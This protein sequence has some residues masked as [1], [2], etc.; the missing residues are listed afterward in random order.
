MAVNFKSVR[1]LFGEPGPRR[2]VQIV[3]ASLA[4]FDLIFYLFAIGPLGESDRER[5]LQGQSLERQLRDRQQQVARLQAIVRKV[6]TARVEG[7]KLLGEITLPRRTAFSTIVSEL[8]DAGKQ[9]GVELRDRG[10]NVDAIEGSETL[11]MLTITQGLEGNYEN[12]VRFLN[13]LDRSRRF[14]IIESLGAAPQQSGAQQSGA[15][16]SVTLKL[17]AFVKES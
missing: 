6:E 4:L 9:A 13:L 1:N 16:L 5:R 10:L 14:L 3:L 2:N 17:D 11:S 15:K 8:D 7:D 12:L